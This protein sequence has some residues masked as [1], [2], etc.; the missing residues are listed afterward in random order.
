MKSGDTGERCTMEAESEE[1]DAGEEK[2]VFVGDGSGSESSATPGSSVS[3]STCCF[4]CP[5][6]LL[7]PPPA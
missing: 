3:N 5:A 1:P 2:Y 4:A 6:L 7:P